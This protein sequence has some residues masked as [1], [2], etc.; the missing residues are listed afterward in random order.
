MCGI[1]APT[2]LCWQTAWRAHLHV[3]LACR[4]QW[5]CSPAPKQ[6]RK[7]AGGK[8]LS[9]GIISRDTA[10]NVCSLP[11]YLCKQAHGWGR[12]VCAMRCIASC[13][14]CAYFEQNQLKCWTDVLLGQSCPSSLKYT[15]VPR[16]T[17]SVW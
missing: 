9:A 4:L 10:V 7:S 11:A 13:L 3:G 8:L 14:L 16:Q 2:A 12:C 1:V 17:C 5:R 15:L 6:N